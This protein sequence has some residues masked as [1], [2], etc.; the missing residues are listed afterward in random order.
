MAWS[1]PPRTVRSA[2]SSPRRFTPRS[3]TRPSTGR[4]QIAVHTVW[5][6]SWTGRGTP[7]FTASTVAGSATGERRDRL[8]HLDDVGREHPPRPLPH[9]DR[10]VRRSRR[11][12]ERVA[13]VQRQRG[14]VLDHHLH[15]SGEDV[16]DLLTGMRV[17]AR[18]DPGRD[19]G[20]HLDDLPAGDRG[21]AVL[22][23][24]PLEFSGEL[25]GGARAGRPGRGH[26]TAAAPGAAWWSNA[27][28][29]RLTSSAWVT[30]IT[31]GP[32]A[33]ST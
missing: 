32:P 23:L 29:S 30:H 2:W 9:V 18:L 4:F 17:P 16:A 15:G 6:S 25:V 28:S 12:E 3:G 21:C 22:E 7:T 5:P 27:S 10:V 26:Q 19:L 11:N 13:G 33:I 31:C 14:P 1:G 8:A 24:G 20:E